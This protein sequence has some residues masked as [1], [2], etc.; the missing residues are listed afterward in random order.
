[1]HSHRLPAGVFFGRE[2]E[3]VSYHFSLFGNPI[4]FCS[5]YPHHHHHHIIS[6]PCLV[7]KRK[8]EKKVA[9][10]ARRQQKERENGRKK[11]KKKKKKRRSI[12]GEDSP[13]QNNQGSFSS[14]SSGRMISHLPKNGVFFLFPGE[15]VFLCTM[16]R[17]G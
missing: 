13:I 5:S 11:K 17:V 9:Y 12:C 4:F 16:E 8:K 3:I 2:R 14:L 1:M 7:R 6:P 10:F 15:E